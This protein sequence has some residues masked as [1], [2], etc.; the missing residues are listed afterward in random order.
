M[1]FMPYRKQYAKTFTYAWR[2]FAKALRHFKRVVLHEVVRSLR[3]L[4]F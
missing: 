3:G 4:R 1:S 2:R